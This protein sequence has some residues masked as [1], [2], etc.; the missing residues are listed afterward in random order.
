MD[1]CALILIKM[2]MMMVIIIMYKCNNNV[3]SAC[4]CVMYCSQADLE[5][6]VLCVMRYSILIWN[7]PPNS[8]IETI[9]T[10]NT[11]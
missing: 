10:A 2:M 9:N 8:V 7:S 3:T 5:L 11:A 1:P 4:C 6:A